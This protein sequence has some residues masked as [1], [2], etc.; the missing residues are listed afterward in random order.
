M[1]EH[2]NWYRKQQSLQNTIIVTTRKIIHRRFEVI[3]IGYIQDTSK[4]ICIIIQANK[5]I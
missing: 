2:T 5:Y 1:K 4:N 3:I